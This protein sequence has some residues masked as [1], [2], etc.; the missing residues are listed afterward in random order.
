VSYTARGNKPAIAVE[1]GSYA[2]RQLAAPTTTGA[3][4][5]QYYADGKWLNAESGK[6]FD[7]R[8]P[9]TGN[10]FARIPAGGRREARIAVEA[11]A[12]AF[13][14]WVQVTPGEK[15]KLFFKAAEVVRRRRA[16]I[17]G[18]LARE[19]GCTKSLATLQQDSV[20]ASIERAASWVYLPGGRALLSEPPG[21]YFLGVHRPGGMVGRFT[22][23]SGTN[24]LSWHAVLPPLAAGNTVVVRPSEVAPVSAGLIV[25]QIAEE[26]GFPPGVINVVTHGPQE[27]A[28]VADEIFDNPAVRV[29]N[30]IGGNLVGILSAA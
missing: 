29:V 2:T 3:P 1:P 5:Y 24:V 12:R 30:L 4:T 14:A 25:A 23:W 13:P 22:P 8:E 18:F 7:V 19:T 15:A 9:D 26:A 16:E 20:A 6:L 21:M 28:L 17:A 27:A 11:A 10:L